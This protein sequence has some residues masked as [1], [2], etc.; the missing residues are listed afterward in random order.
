MNSL[1]A[2]NLLRYRVTDFLKLSPLSISIGCLSTNVE[3][4]QREKPWVTVGTIGH[5]DHGKTTLTSAITKVLEAEGLAQYQ[6]YD[7]IDSTIEEKRRGIT[8]N[9]ASVNYQSKLRNYAH[10]DCPGHADYIKNMISGTVQMDGTIL[11]VAA[12]DSV[13]PQTKEHVILAKQIGV[14]DLVVYINKTDTVDDDEITQLVE[15]EVRELL[16]IHGFDSDK[17]PFV[18][19]SALYALNDKDPVKGRDSIINLVEMLDKHVRLPTRIVDKPFFFNVEKAITV[20]GRG[21]VAVG[22]LERGIIEKGN[23]AEILGKSGKIRTVISQI[24]M[25]YKEVPKAMSGDSIGA[26]LRG[27]SKDKVRRGSIIA[28]PGS[29]KLVKKADVKLYVLSKEEGGRHTP[30]MKGY[31]PVVFSRMSAVSAIVTE[32]K[33]GKEMVMPGEDVELTF[34]FVIP[35]AIEEGKRFTVRDSRKTIATGVATKIYS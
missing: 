10:V 9:A 11:V 7:R 12:T 30:F 16:D 2:R 32:L 28:K 8:I 18:A 3:A 22:S 13:M 6:T 5:V 4:I 27:V 15:L 35:L 17:I 31:K 21:T 23:E 25:F 26:L 14:E 1:F 33:G 19:G 20:K 24:Q 29:I 34:E